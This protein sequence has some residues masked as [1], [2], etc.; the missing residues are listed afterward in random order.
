ML[1]INKDLSWFTMDGVTV[2][3]WIGFFGGVK[4]ENAAYAIEA[5]NHVFEKITAA[6][7]FTPVEDDDGNLVDI[8]LKKGD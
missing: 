3:Q 2:S 7:G 4:P 5:D 1:V 6:C 8:V